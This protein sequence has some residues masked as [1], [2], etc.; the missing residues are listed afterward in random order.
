MV[1][2]ECLLKMLFKGYTQSTFA[3]A[4]IEKLLRANSL[5][6]LRNHRRIMDGIHAAFWVLM[7]LKLHL[8]IFVGDCLVGARLPDGEAGEPGFSP[9]LL[10]PMTA[11]I[12]LP[13][14][15]VTPS[16]RADE[17]RKATVKYFTMAE[18]AYTG[19]V[20]PPGPT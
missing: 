12:I 17:R 8:P 4:V 19:C 9:P 14:S 5:D 3:C 20:A 15:I 6:D 1:D 18:T 10:A 11:R 7:Q 16:V 2:F 13:I